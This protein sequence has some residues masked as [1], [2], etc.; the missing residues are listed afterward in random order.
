MWYTVCE[1]ASDT[2]SNNITRIYSFNLV[3]YYLNNL[4]SVTASSRHKHLLLV[5]N[6]CTPLQSICAG[7]HILRRTSM[8]A[9]FPPVPLVQLTFRSK[10]E[11]TVLIR[12][13]SIRY[14]LTNATTT[15]H[16]HSCHVC[17]LAMKNIWLISYPQSWTS[18][19]LHARVSRF[20][21]K[22]WGSAT[23]QIY[24]W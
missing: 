22:Y 5:I 6:V 20:Q 7:E 10:W 2:L 14:C 24:P 15:T 17:R 23:V 3:V 1:T 19:W 4:Q 16:V 9:D 12:S 18:F 11:K 21:R 13:H 8:S